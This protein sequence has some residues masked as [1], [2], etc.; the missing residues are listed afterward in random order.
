M[1]NPVVLL[2]KEMDGWQSSYQ[3]KHQNTVTLWTRKG[4]E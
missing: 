2:G 3:V 4:P 1:T